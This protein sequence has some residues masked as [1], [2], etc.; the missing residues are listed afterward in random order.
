MRSS[1]IHLS[2]LLSN[3]ENCNEQITCSARARKKYRKGYCMDTY[4]EREPWTN[5]GRDGNIKFTHTVGS[6]KLKED[7]PRPRGLESSS[8]KARA[9][10]G[11]IA[12]QK[13]IKVLIRFYIFA[14]S[15]MKFKTRIKF[16]TKQIDIKISKTQTGTEK[17]IWKYHT[18]TAELDDSSTTNFPRGFTFGYIMS[19]FL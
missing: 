3:S 13:L 12:P 10:F 6:A 16:S 15:E 4:K 2:P 19:F 11:D 8:G 17:T 5:F 1:A 9:R 18:S 7:I 14:K